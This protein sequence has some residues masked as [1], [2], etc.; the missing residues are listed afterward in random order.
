MKYVC[1]LGIDP[2]KATKCNPSECPSCGWEAEEALNQKR[3]RGQKAMIGINERAKEIHK[4]AVEHGW[5]DTERSFPEI[6]ALVHSELS[7]A[8]EE[9]RDGRPLI[10]FPCNAGG[11]C[12]DDRPEENV[13]CGSRP[14]DPE[15]PEAPCSARSKKPEGI[16]VELADAIIR[17]LD[18]CGYAGIDIEAAIR[19]KHEYKNYQYGII[20]TD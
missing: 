11:L 20:L 12:V 7:E 6:I 9:Y 16:A 18:Y 3:K 19:Q 2:A 10:Y 1:T 4:N 15:N 8:L 14:Y 17:I 5:W 13:S